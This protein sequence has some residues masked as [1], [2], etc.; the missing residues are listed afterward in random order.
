MQSH[1]GTIVDV[2][3]AGVLL[4]GPSG[5]GKSDLAFR[6]IDRGATLIADDQYFVRPGSRA[7][8]A[9]APDELYGLLEVR[10]LGI[11]SVPAL[12]TT[13][14]HLVVDLVSPQDVP[15]L[16]EGCETEV[17]GHKIPIMKLNAFEQSAPLKIELA[18]SN[19]LSIGRTER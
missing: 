6:L 17:C 11:Q 12:K 2:S 1:H 15:R 13:R 9:S 8:V 7:P 4:R 19:P 3:G 5:C 10:G 18:A 14:L 16:P